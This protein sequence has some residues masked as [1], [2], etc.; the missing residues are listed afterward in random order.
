[1]LKTLEEPAPHTLVLLMTHNMGNLPV[2]IRSRCQ[3]W[4][5]DHP[6]RQT[7]IAWLQKQGMDD[8]EAEQYIDFSA[9]D[10]QLA[11]KLRVAEYATLVDR[12]KQ[13]FLSYLKNEIDVSKLCSSVASIEVSIIRRLIRMVVIAYCYQLIGLNKKGVASGFANKPAAQKVLLL[14]SRMD[15]QLMVEENNL[16]LQ[17]QLE[18]V[19]ISL[20]Q[21]IKSE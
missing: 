3:I 10:P 7:S 15:R 2:T 18:D 14:A 12:F 19:L 8:A 1:M 17:I 13:L 20:R 21:I 5:L 6:E 11:L 9:G 4:S 16:N